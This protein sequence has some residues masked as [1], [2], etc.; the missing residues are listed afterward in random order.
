[1]GQKKV[2]KK[3]EEETLK[4]EKKTEA[5]VSKT[6]DVSAKAPKKKIDLGRVYINAGYNNTILTATD[7]DGNVLVWTSAGSIGFSGPK[8][9]TPF[10]A[11]KMVTTAAEKMKKLGFFDIEI[12]IKGTSKAR[13]AALKALAGVGFNILTIKDVTPIPHNGPKPPKARRI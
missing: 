12:F 11:S 2:I 13:D 4:E 3:T 9:A 10:A 1:M 7:K 6:A 5:A 8:K